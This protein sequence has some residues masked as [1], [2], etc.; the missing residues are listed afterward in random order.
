MTAYTVTVY[1]NVDDD[2]FFGYK[3]RHPIAK[4]D[5]FTIEAANPALAA[6]SMFA[7]GNKEVGPDSAGKNYPRDVRSISVGDVIKLR[8]PLYPDNADSP[9]ATWFYAVASVGW[10][11]IPE[12][13]NPIVALEGTRATSRTTPTEEQA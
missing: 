10:T 2:N 12:P 8:G 4:V 9:I 3:P 6:E 13:A 5:T 7:V 11:E 1:V